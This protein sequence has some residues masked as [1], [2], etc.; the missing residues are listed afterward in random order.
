VKN[1]G[2]G[3]GLTE[4]GRAVLRPEADGTLTLFHS[5]TEMGQGVNTVLL[6]V[7]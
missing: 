7:A 4:Y 3:N 5:W 1:T 2:I 6:Q